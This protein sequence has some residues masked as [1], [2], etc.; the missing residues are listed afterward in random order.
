MVT[1]L[2]PLKDRV[3]ITS[4]SDWAIRRLHAIDPDLLLGFDPLLYLEA[5]LGEGHTP[6]VP[7]FRQGAYGYWDDHPLASWRWGPAAEYLAVRAE[8]LLAQV[9]AGI[10]WYIHAGLLD[11]ALDDGF[12]WIATTAHNAQV[13]A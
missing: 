6:G 12:D 11:K 9:P 4:P 2:Q 8:A 1:S 13:D 7:P 5:D 3:R 10:I